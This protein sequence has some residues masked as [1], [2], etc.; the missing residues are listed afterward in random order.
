MTT[1]LTLSVEKQVVLKAKRYAQETGK[2]LSEII[3]NYLEHLTKEE[4]YPEVSEKLKG[5][6]GAVKLPDDFDED[7]AKRSYLENKY[8]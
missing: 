1:K 4:K 5:L 3:Q 2:S 6:L 8:R 7:K